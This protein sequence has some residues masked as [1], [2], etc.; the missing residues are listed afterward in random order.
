M[1]EQGDWL[2]Q[3]AQWQQQYWG[4]LRDLGGR[5]AAGG[6]FGA[7]APWSD[8]M[9][10]WQRGGAPNLASMDQS[11]V[12]ERMLGYGRQ[13]LELMQGLMTGRGFAGA[14]A[15][16]DPQAWLGELRELQ[17][18]YGQG[19][20]GMLG[21][22]P[23]PPWFG[24][25][26]PAQVE[27]MVR[28]FTAAPMRAAQQEVQGWLSLPAF[29]LNREHSERGQALLRA[30]L[31]YQVASQRYNELMLR[32]LT[33]TFDRLESR[34]AER[35]EPGR[36]IESARALYDLWIDAAE[37]AYQEIA[38][39]AEF[40]EIYGELVNTQMRVRAGLNAE[41]ER[42]FGQFGMPTR[43]EVDSLARQVHEL[44]R[45]L[46]KG[47][48]ASVATADQRRPK[49]QPA[50]AASADPAEPKSKRA[51]ARSAPPKASKKSGKRSSGK[52][53]R[54]SPAT[55]TRVDASAADKGARAGKRRSQA[56]PELQST[57]RKRSQRKGD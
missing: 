56:A 43:T 11:E 8:P 4:G 25:I 36:R 44:K 5:T 33:R 10:A 49:A 1:N 52:R 57:A 45:Q 41:I 7:S 40:R 39:S 54:P 15:G 28:S 9:A 21:P 18:R 27:Q 3:M 29:G 34:L 53:A 51:T 13:Y 48:A 32:S 14:G 19:L 46:R 24:D 30:W 17:Q 6:P 47:A 55:A 42:Y 16:F 31:D 22:T 26:D 23:A 20:N 35:D 50:S 2:R 12:V 38:L 37:D